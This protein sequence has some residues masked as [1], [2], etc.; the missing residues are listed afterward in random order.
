MQPDR[1]STRTQH[2]SWFAG[3]ALL[4]A[5]LLLL[6]A[7]VQH[8]GSRAAPVRAWVADRDAH[9]V[10]G[11]DGDLLRVRELQLGWPLAVA[12]RTD[13]G[14]WVL[15]SG[16]GTP[17]FGARLTSVDPA[18]ALVNETW[19][20][21][22]ETLEL[23][24]GRDALVIE[25]GGAGKG[26][27]RVWRFAPDGVGRILA[28]G[29]RFNALCASRGT[30]VLGTSDGVLV[31]VAADGTRKELARVVTD[32]SFGALAAGPHPGSIFALDTGP[33]RRLELRGDDLGVVW[34]VALGF[35]A[36]HVGVVPGAER[37]WVSDVNGARARRYGP[38]GA[39]ELECALPLHGSDHALAFGDGALFAAPGAVLRVDAQGRLRPGQG[40]FAWLSGL[41]RAP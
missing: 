33:G 10:L 25:L 14:L 6:P 26:R 23:I 32:R 22:S 12:A 38:G 35:D 19:L 9:R 3:G 17:S 24:E 13:G 15:R 27:D 29:E 11:L 41:A 4:A 1:S 20:E 36:R 40:G 34:S 39:L 7:A 37:A 8:S 30:V 16:N 31:R 5:L 2:L 21:N 28:E 18:G